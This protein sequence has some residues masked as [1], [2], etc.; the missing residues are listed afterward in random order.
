M[1]K[2]SQSKAGQPDISHLPSKRGFIQ[3]PP[4]TRGPSGRL[5]QLAASINESPRVQALRQLGVE[6]QRNSAMHATSAGAQSTP[7]ANGNGVAQRVIETYDPRTFEKTRNVTA[8][9]AMNYLSDKGGNLTDG[10]KSWRDEV[11]L[12]LG[13]LGKVRARL[14]SMVASKAVVDFAEGQPNSAAV[15]I[16]SALEKAPEV[17]TPKAVG[18]GVGLLG[19]GVYKIKGDQQK[20]KEEGKKKVE[21]KVK[22]KSKFAPFDIYD[23]TA[24]F[25]RLGANGTLAPLQVKFSQDTAGFN[26]SVA[27]NLGGQEV[28][29]VQQHAEAMK[30]HGGGSTP[31]IEVVLYKKRIMTLN[32]RRLKAHQL[33]NVPIPY[34]KSTTQIGDDKIST[35]PNVD[36]AAPRNNL[37]L[38]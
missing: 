13:G 10:Q 28:R 38:R 20:E 12:K 7:D 3:D 36:N 33:A 8:E 34:A 6:M 23:Q 32:N 15:A 22:K 1:E 5:S 2:A 25:N 35:H 16:L 17:S 30:K 24:E 9:E 19:P 31:P 26:Y 14:E 4:S 18:P 27:F 37:T 21:G 29:T 11:F